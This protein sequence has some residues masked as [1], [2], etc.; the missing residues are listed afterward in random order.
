MDG[1]RCSTIWA[2]RAAARASATSWSTAGR[3]SACRTSPR[4]ISHPVKQLLQ[5]LQQLLSV[6]IVPLGHGTSVAPILGMM[7]TLEGE[8]VQILRD[9][10]EGSLNE[11][12]F[13]S[14]RADAHDYRE[15]LHRRERVVE[16]LLQQ[17]RTSAAARAG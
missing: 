12:R 17:L 1:R 6:S 13:E 11:L 3:S 4:S 7:L 15:M 16:S 5:I 14:S 9:I 2:R 8:Q 10:L